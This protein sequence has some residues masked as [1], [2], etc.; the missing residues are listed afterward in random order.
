MCLNLKVPLWGGQKYFLINYGWLIFSHLSL[1]A[2]WQ[3]RKRQN[4]PSKINLWAL[5]SVP[6]KTVLIIS[7]TCY[8]FLPLVMLLIKIFDRKC[9]KSV[10]FSAAMCPTWTLCTG[11]ALMPCNCVSLS[12]IKLTSNLNWYHLEHW[13]EVVARIACSLS[14]SGVLY[15]VPVAQNSEELT[16]SPPLTL[17]FPLPL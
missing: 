12:L 8:I 4:S 15:A 13:S 6:M 1:S 11:F 14:L 17:S 9:H 7:G 16:G 2:K 3:L 10:D 5:I